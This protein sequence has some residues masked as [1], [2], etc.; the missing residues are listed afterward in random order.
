MLFSVGTRVKFLHSPDE[1]VVTALL[2]DGMVMVLLDE[3]DM[4]IPAFEDDLIRAELPPGALPVKAKIIPGKEERRPAPPPRPQPETQYTILKSRG[5]Q[6]AFAPVPDLEENVERYDIFLINDTPYEFLFTFLLQLRGSTGTPRNGKLP[7][8]AYVPVGEL[9]FD[10]LNDAPLA[11]LTCWRITTAGTGPRL[12]RELRIRPKQFFKRIATAPLLNRQVHLFRVFEKVKTEDPR[13]PGEEDLRSYTRRNLP[14]R[15][16]GEWDDLRIRLPH[17]ILELAEF[18]PECDLHIEQLVADHHK[19]SNAEILRLQIRHFEHYLNKAINVGVERVFIIHGL[20]TGRLR[21][22]IAGRLKHR[23]E[24]KDFKNEY[25]PRYG[26][27]A[28]EV[29]FE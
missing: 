11:E 9:L 18:I 8:R 5:I 20:G 26:W 22:A 25:H 1:G 23:P 12:F 14:Q 3:E 24:V 13:R 10:Q 28:T 2:G 29:I 17:D 7:A 15:P 4:E 16:A 27:G 6:L 19:M 21:D